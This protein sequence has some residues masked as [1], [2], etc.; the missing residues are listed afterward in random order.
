VEDCKE[1]ELNE[2]VSFGADDKVEA[3]QS[4]RRV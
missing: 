1:G 4:S 2:V 3:P